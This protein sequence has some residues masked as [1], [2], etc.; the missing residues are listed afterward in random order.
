MKNIEYDLHI[1][2]NASDGMLNP[3]LIMEIALGKGLKGI[4]I[5]DH[6][7]IGSLQECL[8]IS[9]NYNLDFI[10][11]IELSTNYNGVEV[12]ILGYYIDYENKELMDFLQYLQRYRIERA[13][14][15]VEIIDGLGYKI[16]IDE[17]LRYCGE[18][19]NSIGRPHVGRLLVDKGY[20]NDTIEVF[21]RL[22]DYGKPAYIENCKVDI[23]EA[24]SMIRR[25][26]GIPILAHPM[27]INGITPGNEF[28]RLI[29]EAIDY[30]INGIEVFH[31][32]HSCN[33]EQY[34]LDVA[35]KNNLIITGGS[36]CHG[37]MGENGYS[38]GCKGVSMNEILRLKRL[39]D[40]EW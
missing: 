39:K 20:F 26:G 9:V 40:A 10:P 13:S 31:T 38:I 37:I 1:H 14:K 19:I 36:D 18:N 27:L 22:L 17:V 28:E 11:G 15:M 21:N 8:K 16:T 30:G 3:N 34:L 33:Q 29:N 12:H 25:A 32:L 5:T 23:K 2:S 4:A 7:T 6:D 24:A 35:N